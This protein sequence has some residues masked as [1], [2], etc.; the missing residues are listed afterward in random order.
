ML[1]T[2]QKVLVFKPELV[3]GFTCLLKTI[4]IESSDER[5]QILVLEVAGQ[6]LGHESYLV[7]D[8]KFISS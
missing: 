4:H 6:D 5:L 3:R 2:S 8:N 7:L 1:L